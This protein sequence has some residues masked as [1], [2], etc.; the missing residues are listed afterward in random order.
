MRITGMLS[1]M[2]L[3]GFCIPAYASIQFHPG[4]DITS[5]LNAAI[6]SGQNGIGP[7]RAVIHLPAG[8]FKLSGPINLHGSTI[9][10][11]GPDQT[12]L[13]FSSDLGK[14]ITGFTGDVYAKWG[15]F[16]IENLKIHAPRPKVQLNSGDIPN[17][18]NGVRLNSN[19][20]LSNV[21][22]QYFNSA[23]IIDGN[24][25]TI[26]NSTIQSNYVGLE[27]VLSSDKSYFDDYYSGCSFAANQ[28]AGIK[29]DDNVPMGGVTLLRV[30]TGFE[31]Y[32]ILLGH[33]STISGCLFL[34]TQFEGPGNA[35]IADMDG[36]SIISANYFASC[37]GWG[38]RYNNKIEKDPIS[39]SFRCGT[40]LSNTIFCAAMMGPTPGDLSAPQG[41]YGNIWI[42]DA[43]TARD[44]RQGKI[45]PITSIRTNMYDNTLLV[46]GVI[47]K[48][49][50]ASAPIQAGSLVQSDGAR[51][52]GCVPYQ[53][54]IP[55]GRCLM[56][57][58]QNE[59]A[60]ISTS[61]STI[62]PAI[63]ARISKDRI[64]K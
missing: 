35:D 2:I 57:T 43:I 36:T 27:Y 49:V 31:P 25:H 16:T 21:N 51:I 61:D 42:S 54:G 26:S 1:V 56:S 46:G 38:G 44:I 19:C 63:L 6:A 62:S 9:S 64:P 59:V 29:V 22:L 13:E 12:V 37:G 53:K 30:H 23:V 40:F 47:Y 34:Q 10:G 45:K 4:A 11:E 58:P 48:S 52:P 17:Q 8:S 33:N 5:D 14:D 24:H 55:M 20:T 32:S 50:M 41:L 18:M 39:P 7:N 15:H 3:L 28:L 60:W